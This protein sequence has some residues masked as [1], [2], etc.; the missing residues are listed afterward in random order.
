MICVFEYFMIKYKKEVSKMSKTLI[1]RILEM[2]PAARH[3]LNVIINYPGLH[4][5][6][7]FRIYHFLWKLHLKLIARFF[8]SGSTFF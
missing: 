5:M 6:F 8:K 1:G 2:D 4:A 7:L 3:P